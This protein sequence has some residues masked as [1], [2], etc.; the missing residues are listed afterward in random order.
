MS[1]GRQK[2]CGA[3]DQEGPQ[4]VILRVLPLLLAKL[5]LLPYLVNHSLYMHVH[6]KQSNAVQILTAP[7]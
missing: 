4:S 3:K 5:Y 7:K 2:G 6:I 1:S